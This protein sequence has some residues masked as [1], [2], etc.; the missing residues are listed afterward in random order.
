MAM[1]LHQNIKIRFALLRKAIKLR[2]RLTQSEIDAVI[3]EVLEE[4]KLLFGAVGAVVV[5][6]A[7]IELHLDF[8][9]GVLVLQEPN[10][11]IKLP[12]PLQSRINFFKDALDRV[13]QL[14]HLRERAS[15]AVDQ[16]NRLKEVRHDIVHGMAIERLP[17]GTRKF[18]RLDFAGK[19]IKQQQSPRSITSMNGYI[20]F[21]SKL[22]QEF[23]PEFRSS[24][25]FW[26]AVEA[27]SECF[28][29]RTNR[30]ARETAPVNRHDPHR[31]HR[32]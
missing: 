18:L 28:Q 6:W 30:P 7:E 32:D 11:N 21:C 2:R 26:Q 17:D 24:G 31:K 29:A 22:E 12:K 8:I 1:S 16:L 9:N 5:V 13:P 14:A 23:K 3:A 15:E 25:A 10:A 4:S 19:D 27:R 20:E